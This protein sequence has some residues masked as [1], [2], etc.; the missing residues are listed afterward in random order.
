M[1][2]STTLTLLDCL[3]ASRHLFELK[4]LSDVVLTAFRAQALSYLSVASQA[5]ITAMFTK[6]LGSSG[7]V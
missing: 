2:L 1:I 3:I 6:I 7:N 5:S 4:C